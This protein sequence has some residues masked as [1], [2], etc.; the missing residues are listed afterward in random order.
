MATMEFGGEEILAATPDRVYDFL[1][2]LDGFPAVIPELVS[3][4]RPDPSTLQC[5]VRPGF[6]FLRG[7]MKLRFTLDELVPPSSAVM[8]IDAAGI[9]VSMKVA[10]RMKFEPYADA[11]AAGGGP[12]TKVVWQSTVSDLKGLV[13]TISPG[14][15]RSAAD[16][17]LQHGWKKLRE[18]LAQS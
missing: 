7:T 4:E 16:Q 2:D 3:H 8:R 10:S 9:G 15:V 11:A 12:A 6:S 5:V 1:T 14:L 13:A 17:V 18:K